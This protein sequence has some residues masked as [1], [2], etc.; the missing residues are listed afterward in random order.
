LP[1]Y[2]Q[3]I[4]AVLAAAAIALL[5]VEVVHRALHRLGRRS[6]LLTELAEHAHR[7]FQLAGTV[8]AVQLVVRHGTNYALHTTWRRVLV[9]VLVLA[10]I[11]GAAWLVAALLLAAEDTA[12][13][14]FRVDVPDNR[15]A[16]R[17]RTQVVML[18]RVTIAVMVVLTLGAMLMTFPGVR[19]IGASVLASAGV[20]G[21]VAALA[22]QTVLG[23]VFAGIQLAF[24][25]AVRLDDVVVVEGEWGR[26][27]ELTLSYVVVQIWDDRRLILPTSYFTSKPFQNWTRTRAAVLG[28]ADL[29]VD[30]SVPVQLMREELRRMVEGTSLWDGRV[31][32]LQVTEATGGMVRVRALVSA[33]DAPSLWDLRCLVREH[34]VGWIRDQVPI[35]LPRTRAEIGHAAEG[36]DWQGKPGGRGGAAAGPEAPDDARVFGGSDDGDARSNAFVG[37]EEPVDVP[38]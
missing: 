1:Q 5:V 18:R 3:T 32:V 37:P 16:R 6:L 23:N 29:D 31:C 17:I 2:V 22:A 25:D 14:R 26:V 38:R 28:T 24:S 33:A 20:I 34:L 7:P 13:A 12:L 19:G 27:E 36:F 21:V 11:A 35:A 15:Q 30:W 4:V 10:F 8:L 9:Q